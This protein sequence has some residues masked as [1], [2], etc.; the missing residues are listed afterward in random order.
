MQS[1]NGGTEMNY[2]FI[3]VFLCFVL[4]LTGCDHGGGEVIAYPNPETQGTVATLG[5]DDTSFG[6][7]IEDSGIY[8]G[9]FD[10]ITQTIA[11]EWVSG[12]K[13]AYK[14]EGSTITFTAL[15]EDTVYQISG[16]FN[17]NIVIDV[18]DDHKFELELCGFSLVSS[19]ANPICIL[20][21]INQ[22]LYCF[23]VKHSL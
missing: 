8:D 17:G 2:K 19:N 15:S 16:Q 23:F 12:T 4:L 10:E 13:N 20:S 21:L 11:V 14:V 5:D 3:A 7:E 6:E 9:L 18:G 1:Y 22:I